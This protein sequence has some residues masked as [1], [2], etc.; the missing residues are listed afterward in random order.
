MRPDHIA[1]REKKKKAQL[2]RMIDILAPRHVAE[3]QVHKLQFSFKEINYH[4]L[5]IY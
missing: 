3:K 4:E 1:A 5:T 2:T